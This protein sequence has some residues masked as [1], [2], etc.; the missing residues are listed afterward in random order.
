M[1]VPAIESSAG[2]KLHRWQGTAG[3]FHALD[4][5]CDRAVWLCEPSAP[6]LVLGST[7]PEDII[8]REAAAALGLEVA[9]RRSGGGVVFVDPT[10]SIWI[11][12]TIPRGDPL[13]V[14]DVSASMIWLG[15]AFVDA[16]RGWMTG[17]TYPGPFRQGAHGRDVCFAGLSPGEVL[18]ATVD[19]DVD[20]KV[21]GISQ[22]RG[23]E[24]ARF[25]CLLYRRWQP[26]SWSGAFRDPETARAATQM[27]IGCV[28]A[29]AGEVVEALWSVLEHG[30]SAPGGSVASGGG[31][32]PESGGSGGA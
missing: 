27:D 8:D 6:A 24:G 32:S 4:L 23:R 29:T 16:L 19:R 10:E 20:R 25:Q 11:D 22:R 2:W 9:R 30:N 17:T 1:S 15:E 26:E 13:W 3:E 28:P 18:A 31:F 14:E 12:V 7:Q 21:V 5:A